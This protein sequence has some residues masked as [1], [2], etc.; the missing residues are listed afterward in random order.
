M[1]TSRRVCLFSCPVAV[2]VVDV[3]GVDGVVV[4][5]VVAVGGVYV[6][7]GGGDDLVVVVFVSI[8]VAV[9]IVVVVVA[10]AAFIV[11]IDGDED[12][13]LLPVSLLPVVMVA[14]VAGTLMIGNSVEAFVYMS[15]IGALN[16]PIHH[17]V[18]SIV[19]QK[20]ANLGDEGVDNGDGTE[21][22]ESCFKVHPRSSASPLPTHV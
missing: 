21:G 3:V 13:P 17:R 5:G 4:D 9:D 16:S 14:V 2:G 6:I 7:G 19:G 8:V 12:V 20:V 10:V 11:A 18:S 15:M 1:F 22:N